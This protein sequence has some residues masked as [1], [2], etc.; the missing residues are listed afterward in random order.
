M[1]RLGQLALKVCKATRVQLA[2]R[3]FKVLP[4]PLVQPVPL[5]LLGRMARL[6]PTGFQ[7]VQGNTGATG[8]TGSQG[9]AGATGATGATGPTGPTGIAGTNGSNGTTGATG[10]TGPAGTNGVS[11]FADFFALMPPDNAATVPPGGPV[12][13]PQDGVSSGSGISRTSASTFLLTQPGVYQVIFQVSVSEP[14]QLVLALN[15]GAGSVEIP[16]TV[17]G[18]STGTSQIVGTALV[19]TVVFNS[20]L[21][22]RNPDGGVFILTIT[23]LA[24]EQIQFQRIWLLLD[25]KDRPAPPVPLGPLVSN[26][27]LSRVAKLVTTGNGS[28]STRR[29]VRA[30]V[31]FERPR[32]S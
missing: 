16:S 13:F 11:D 21:E 3:V 32:L 20:I 17:V 6:G 10:A 18:R 14:G 5:A 4:E 12:A 25:C 2:I 1:A 30:E 22:V 26:R 28:R 23:P 31:Q 8:P 29:R 15:Q 9:I 27:L 24:G 7:G 19:Q